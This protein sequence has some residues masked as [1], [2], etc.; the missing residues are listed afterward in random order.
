M[1]KTLLIVSGGIEAIP[2]I[3]TAKGMGLHVIVSD[4]NPQAP[5]FVIAD[6]QIIACTYDVEET[7]QKAKNYHKSVRKLDGVMCIA[8]DIPFTVAS[9][10]AELGLPGI[11]VESAHLASDKMAMKEKFAADGVAIPWFSE[12]KSRNELEGI[13][14]S[15][16]LPLVIKPV[17]SRGARGVVRITEDVDLNWAFK[18]ARKNSPTLRVMV[19]QYLSG[20]QISTE[21]MIVNGVAYTPGFSDRNY[22]FLETF[23]PY[24]IEN[25]GDIPSHIP[26]NHYE[27]VYEI[28]EAGARSMG[29]TNGIVKGDIVVENGKAHIIELAARLSG[30]YFCTHEIP[31]NAGV[32]LVRESIKFAIGEPINPEDLKPKFN[33]PVSQRYLFPQPGRVVAIN[34]VDAVANRPEISLCEVRV[35]VGDII[36]P[37]HNHPARAGVVITHADTQT[38]A[39]QAAVAAI[40]DIQIET[41]S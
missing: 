13:V 35:K 15:Q 9:V 21:S 6:D 30:G 38:E 14:D 26:D 40:K 34:G 11:P 16:G 39:R 3:H 4:L 10:A 33:R 19:E 31:L 25:G 32:D 22:E 8:S 7:V 41:V 2:G 37:I 17:D 28:V 36:G 20:P 5:G 1:G 27:A 18:Q 24:I 23:A 12:I 29:I